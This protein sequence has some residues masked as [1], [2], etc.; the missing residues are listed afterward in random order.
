MIFPPKTFGY[1]K[2]LS[3]DYVVNTMYYKEFADLLSANFP[4]ER[5]QYSIEERE[6]DFVLTVDVPG[7]KKEDLDV[8]LQDFSLLVAGTRGKAKFSKKFELDDLADP[9]RIG[10]K[11]AD[12]VLTIIVAKRLAAMPRRIVINS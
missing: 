10:A 3:D 8:S 7:V 4:W 5:P 11:L 6:K 12:G 1:C 2:R 9:E